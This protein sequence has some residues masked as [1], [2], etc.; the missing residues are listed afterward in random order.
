MRANPFDAFGPRGVATMQGVEL[1]ALREFVTRGYEDTTAEHISAAAGVSVRT[2]FRYF[3]R[4]KE[5]V[6]VLEFRRWMHQLAHAVRD[7]PLAE[8][9][10]TAIRAAV[11]AIPLLGDAG[12]STEAVD[13]HHQVAVRHPDLHAGLTGHHLVLA[14]PLVESVAQRMSVDA[15]TSIRPRLMVHSMLGA[16]LVVWLASLA[17]SE[18]D[19]LALFEQALDDLE[20]GFGP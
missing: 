5:D 6:M 3:P 20:A 16:A 2:Y 12:L 15:S 17:D 1:A 18:R 10:W 7:R 8:P 19:G 11:R 4:G 9:A 14:E 13:L